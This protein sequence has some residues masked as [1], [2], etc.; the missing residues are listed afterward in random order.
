LPTLS[1]TEHGELT[2][3]DKDLAKKTMRKI[4]GLGYLRESNKKLSPPPV[5]KVSLSSPS[6]CI[7][8]PPQSQKEKLDPLLYHH[9]RVVA[10]M[11][12]DGSTGVVQ[13]TVLQQM[14]SV[15]KKKYPTYINMDMEDRLVMAM[16]R[17]DGSTNVIDLIDI[18]S[19][20]VTKCIATHLKKTAVDYLKRNGAIQASISATKSETKATTTVNRTNTMTNTTTSGGFGIGVVAEIQGEPMFLSYDIE[21]ADLICRPVGCLG[22]IEQIDVIQ[23]SSLSILSIAIAGAHCRIVLSVKP[24]QYVR[25]LFIIFFNIKYLTVTDFFL[26]FSSF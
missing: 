23:I 8:L 10:S 20:N 2:Q 1:P 6:L 14:L 26:F 17:N 9:L 24:Y 7:P 16:N 5:P 25:N 12:E 21:H 22:L 11:L 15:W 19:H 4:K 13:Y 3:R 18:L